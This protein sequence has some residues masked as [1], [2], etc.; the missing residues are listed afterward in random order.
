MTYWTGDDEISEMSRSTESSSVFSKSFIE[1]T[2]NYKV[3]GYILGAYPERYAML[4]YTLF[5]KQD[6]PEDTS[7]TTAAA[8][9]PPAST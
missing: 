8:T 5:E 3:D 2:D 4:G 7:T 6:I 9:T 1:P